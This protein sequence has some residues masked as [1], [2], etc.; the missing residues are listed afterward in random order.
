[1]RVSQPPGGRPDQETVPDHSQGVQ[2]AVI[3]ELARYW[4]RAGAVRRR[5]PR[6]VPVTA[7]AAHARG[8]RPV[9]AFQRRSIPG[10]SGSFT[11]LSF[12]PEVSL[13]PK[14]R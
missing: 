2:L 5:G 14:R 13:A 8:H 1:V 7:L 3:Q 6:G 11:L 12:A 10:L 9:V 4:A